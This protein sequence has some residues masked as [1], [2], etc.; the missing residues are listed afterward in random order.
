MALKNLYT[1]EMLQLS[2]TWIDQTDKA[3]PAIMANADLMPSMPRLQGSHATLSGAHQPVDDTRLGQIVAQE[4]QIDQ[5]HDA[6]IRGIWGFATSKAELLG[7]TAGDALIEVRDIILP[8]GLQSQ[9]KTYMA[10]AGQ[11]NQ[12]AL[13]MT[14][15]VRAKTDAIFVGQVPNAKPLTSFVDE[16]IDLGKQLGALENERGQLEAAG[17]NGAA[18]QDA[19]NQWIRVINA[20]VANAALAGLDAD[21]DALLFGALRAQEKKADQ[22]AREATA[23]KAKAA[24]AALGAGGAAGATGAAGGSGPAGTSQGG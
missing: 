23:A 11:A 20:L 22:R 7:G 3:Y 24:K 12:L 1:D 16:L 17:S 5:R 6:I 9:L 8:D 14:P 18:E 15:A 2:G 19:R 10:E 13:R 4:A 21:T